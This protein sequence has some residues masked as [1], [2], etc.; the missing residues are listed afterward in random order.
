MGRDLAQVIE[1]S[2]RILWKVHGLSLGQRCI[3][4]AHALSDVAQRQKRQRA[5]QRLQVLV[6]A[7]AANLEH[8]VAVADHRPFGRAGGA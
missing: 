3:D 5:L 8:Q 7:N 1:N 2:A 4:R 6:L